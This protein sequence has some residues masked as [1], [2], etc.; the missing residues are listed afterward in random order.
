MYT[1]CLSFH[2]YF[3]HEYKSTQQPSIH[4]VRYTNHDAF[5][6][7]YHTMLFLS[8]LC[9]HCTMTGLTLTVA[10]KMCIFPF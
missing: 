9:F 5:L 7:L 6:V 2:S 3:C 4:S 10:G 8:Q 1:T